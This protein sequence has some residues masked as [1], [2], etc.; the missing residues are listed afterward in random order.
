LRYPYAIAGGA[1]VLLATAAASAAYWVPFGE[2]VL[3]GPGFGDH[4]VAEYGAVEVELTSES[5]EH[6]TAKYRDGR[7]D[8][9]PGIAPLRG[10]GWLLIGGLG[11]GI[12]A[13]IAMWAAPS[14]GM[15]AARGAAWAG[16]AGGLL[17]LAAV[18]ALLMGYMDHLQA[19]ADSQGDGF[20]VESNRITAGTY[21]LGL[22]V[23][24]TFGG[25]MMGFADKPPA[26][27]PTSQSSQTRT[28]VGCGSPVNGRFCP[29]CGTQAS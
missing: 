14:A 10:G 12:A 5:G 22:G 24:L 15:R 20:D 2:A 29:A 26:P 16:L 23:V 9:G 7:F 25:A 17:L 11:L 8:G 18:V 1:I 21:L 28:C 13:A 4:V 27:V 6:S 19:M 3:D